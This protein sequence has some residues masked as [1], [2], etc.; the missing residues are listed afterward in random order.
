MAGAA[1]LRVLR[2]RIKSVQST[3]KITRAM[4]L[5]AA[6]RI[7]KARRAVQAARPYSAG[8]NR[9]VRHL[10]AFPQ[11]KN[12][13][14]LR[15]HPGAGKTCVVV[16]T[17]DRGLAGAYNIN[18]IRTAYDARQELLSHGEQVQMVCVGSKGASWLR[19]RNVE[20]ERAYEGLSDQPSSDAARQ[21]VDPIVRDYR[22]G[23]ID[24]VVVV[25]TAF[26]NALIQRTTRAQILPI[27]IDN[28]IDITVDELKPEEEAGVHP[29]Y[30]MDPGLDVMLDA[31]LP[32]YVQQQLFAAMLESAASEHASRQRAMKAATENAEEVIDTLT[33]K[34][35]TARQAAVTSEISEIVGG[36][37]A[38]ARSAN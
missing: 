4:E 27:D 9:V 6:S 12:H 7:A 26:V 8:M 31:L 13:P 21:V 33:I 17:S 28:P 38:L 25:Y 22:D 19:F 16:I 32:R 3:K 36:A 5:I 15:K 11:A 35:N 10:S 29:E 2:R 37:D 24:Q 14:V 1:E 30:L 18:A 34:A 20:V 23:T